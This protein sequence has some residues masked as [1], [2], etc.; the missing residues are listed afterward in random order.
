M[1]C[2]HWFMRTAGLFFQE[3]SDR[4]PFLAL[5]VHEVCDAMTFPRSFIPERYSAD[6][7]LLIEIMIEEIEVV[8]KII[9]SVHQDGS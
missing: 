5:S 7:L 9:N 2:R 8:L 4:F 1:K 3:K 6:R